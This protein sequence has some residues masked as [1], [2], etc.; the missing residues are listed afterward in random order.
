[1]ESHLSDPVAIP[2]ENP[3]PEETLSE[4]AAQAARLLRRPSL[5]PVRVAVILAGI[6]WL[7]LTV[8]G[9]FAFYASTPAAGFNDVRAAAYA[10]AM[11]A[12]AVAFTASASGYALRNL[13]S[14]LRGPARAL[15]G[16]G[17][18]AILLSW[19]RTGAAFPDFLEEVLIAAF[20]VVVPFRLAVSA[21]ARWAVE[22]GLTARRAVL[23]GG[24]TEAERVVRGLAARPG[25]DIRICAVFDD[26]DSTR[27]PD[28]VLN[29]PKIGRFGDLVAFCRIAEIDLVIICL[30]ATAEQRLSQ[31]LEKFRVLPVQIHLS[32]F[33][34]NLDFSSA[35]GSGLIDASFHAE[36]RLL[37][38]GFDLLFGTILVALLSPLMALIALLIR[39]DSPGPVFFRQSRHG[40]NDRMVNVWKFRSMYTDQCDVSALRIVTRGDPRV[41]RIGRILRKTS[42]DELP[43]LFNVLGG[44]L[45]L[46]GPRPHAVDARSTAQ[47]SFDQIVQ[48]YSA[49]HRLPPGITGWAQIHGL[50][51]G[52]D[53]PEALQKRIAFDLYYI[54]NWSLWLDFLILL[55]TPF[56]LFDTRH[57]Y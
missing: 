28:L 49:R 44:E 37:K 12:I 1:M 39:L 30:P 19:L 31:L 32:A 10:A 40:F 43:Q 13:T 50:R 25:S 45:S 38:R 11:A 7:L 17:A 4:A 48:G 18:A 16:F 23:A 6:E 9:W 15:A 27:A 53:S 41:T 3:P 42:L 54:E 2:A 34:R 21:A 24:G 33:S 29:V 5:A 14:R 36:R 26:R 56:C 55:K 35:P 47:E 52:V 46:V 20:A 22:S 51:G 8:S 57:A